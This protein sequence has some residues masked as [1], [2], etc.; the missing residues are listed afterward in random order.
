M[1]KA[2]NRH[3]AVSDLRIILNE[4]FPHLPFIGSG[5]NGE[6]WSSEK[7]A[8]CAIGLLNGDDVSPIHPEAREKI[9]K[10]VDIYNS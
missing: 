3:K 6:A 8:G 1:I 4:R 7:V 9:K 2:L 5:S 10:L